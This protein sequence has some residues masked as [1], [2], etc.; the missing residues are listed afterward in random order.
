MAYLIKK[1]DDSRDFDIWEKFIDESSTNGTIF[2]SRKYLSYNKNKYID[3]SIVIYKKELIISVLPCCKCGEKYFSYSGA[4]L[5]GPVFSRYVENIGEISKIINLILDY[6]GNKLEIRIGNSIYN[7]KYNNDIIYLLSKKLNIKL[8]ISWIFEV[9]DN[10]ID[11]IKNIRNKKNLIKMIDK[12]NGYTC[13]KYETIEDYKSFYN[14]LEN[15]LLN[16]YN[17]KPTH[18][19]DELL[20]LKLILNSNINLYMVK[21]S[22]NNIYGGVIVI[23]VT[24]TCWYTIYIAK[25]INYN[26]S[27]NVSIMYIMY[28]IIMEAKQNGIKYIDYGV[29]SENEGDKLNEGLSN[30]KEKSLCGKPIH[31]YLLLNCI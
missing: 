30:Y 9:N 5:G 7:E 6:Y 27:T 8:E 25:N 26:S 13:K 24:K 16:K 17:K 19:L 21:D 10:F 1:Y 14:L 12:E 15:I 29:T 23:N 4:T 11:S 28:E 31:R 20:L 22:V 3:S 2:H 18:T